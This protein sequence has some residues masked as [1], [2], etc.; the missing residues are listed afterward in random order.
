MLR[1]PSPTPLYPSVTRSHTL[2]DPCPHSLS[3]PIFPW[4]SHLIPFHPIPPT[5]APASH[6]PCCV[7]LLPRLYFCISAFPYPLMHTWTLPHFSSSLHYTKGANPRCP[8]SCFAPLI[9]PCLLAITV[10]HRESDLMLTRF[11]LL[12]RFSA[13][14]S[15][16]VRRAIS[17]FLIGR[18]VVLYSLSH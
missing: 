17:F 6:C 14:R 11:R 1:A 15:G 2:I 4:L 5:R 10:N 9:P 12:I 18:V 16:L 13:S 7:V 8:R 3:R